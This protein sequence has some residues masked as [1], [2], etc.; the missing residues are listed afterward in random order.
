LVRTDIR[1]R[2]GRQNN[3]ETQPTRN[4]TLVWSAIDVYSME[5]Y[6]T[7]TPY[8]YP[9]MAKRALN[10]LVAAR[11]WEIVARFSEQASS[12]TLNPAIQK[13]NAVM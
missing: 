10:P 7:G 13:L 6:N 3:T 12:K 5:P 1:P 4:P 11:A 8:R 9:I 2:S